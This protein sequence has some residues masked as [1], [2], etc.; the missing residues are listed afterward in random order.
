MSGPENLRIA[1][2][3]YRG[4]PH[5]GGQGVYVRHLSK[6]L[7]DLGH[8]VEVLGGPPYPILD[9]RV[10][11]V[12]LPSL[13]IW[14]DP[15]PMRKPRIWEWK[16]WTDFAEHASFSTGNFSEPMA[17]SLRAWRHLKSRRSEFD[18]IHDN[19]TLGWGL[20]KLQQEGWP[21]LETIHHPITVDRKL[22][23]EHART[24]RER[25]GKRR[26]YSFTK[27]QSQVA[28]RMTRVMSVSQSSKGDIA[29]D[30]G[31]DPDKIH[32]VPVGVD[33]ELFLPVPGVERRP[34][35][36]VTT[37][38]AD[39]AMKGLKF[40]LEAVAK[41]RTERHIELTIIG[42]R[43]PES[44]ASTV[45]TQLGLDDCVDFVSGV[46]DERIVELYSEAELAVV[47]SL[48]EGF[49]LPAIEAMSCGV[50][51]VATTGG[52]LPEVTG[53]HNET[54]FQ[55]EPG[56]SEALAATIR[57]ALDNPELRAK[58]GAQGRERVIDQ[59]SW[60]HT[61]IKT[62]EQYRAVL[63]EHAGQKG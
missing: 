21:I 1:L 12:E 34:G 48:Y 63:A 26:W 18:L 43:R 60:R 39:V 61:A 54:C 13:D 42:K 57:E 41:L 36:L 44:H 46:P 22:E 10:P 2:L 27:M 20:L 3:T 8:H 59:W 28:Q 16:D 56:D 33:P 50:P 23:L 49:S 38:S 58:V 17:F 31:V 53:T 19:Q 5:V 30:H 45:M 15:H 40:L 7:V 11:L 62:V 25:F 37:A 32:V 47:P 52:A 14:S 51:V 55:A 4:K 24:P 9:D 6:A 35:H 29:A